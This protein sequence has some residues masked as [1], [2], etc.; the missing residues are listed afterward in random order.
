MKLMER[1][2]LEIDSK[3]KCLMIKAW[4]SKVF[5]KKSKMISNL[6]NNPTIVEDLPRVVSLGLKSAKLSQI[7]RGVNHI[8]ET[9]HN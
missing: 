3:H 6:E 2:T 7:K 8:E 4:M 9:V 5:I 1:N